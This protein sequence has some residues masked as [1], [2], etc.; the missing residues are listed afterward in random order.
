MTAVAQQA[1]TS[2]AVAEPREIEAPSP[3]RSMAMTDP[4]LGIAASPFPQDAQDVL[5]APLRDDE[6]SV[7]PD[8][9]ILYMSGEAV[10]QRLQKAFGIGGWAIKP[11]STIVDKDAVDLKG[12][13][14]PKVFYT[15]QLWIL[16]RFA[17]EATGDGNWI[18]SNPK[19]D[20]GT[21][22]EGAK[23]NCISRCCKDL[24]MWSELRDKAF[25]K[26][27]QDKNVINTAA[28]GWVKRPRQPVRPAPNVPAPRVG[29]PGAMPKNEEHHDKGKELR[30]QY[31]AT[32]GGPVPPP[33]PEDNVKVTKAAKASTV[34]DLKR[35]LDKMLPKPQLQIVVEGGIQVDNEETGERTIEEART[36][37]QNAIIHAL[38]GEL[39]LS[40]K[41]YRH[42]LNKHYHVDTS[43]VLTKAQASDLID[44]LQ[45]TKRNAEMAGV[46]YPQQKGA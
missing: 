32:V 10:R 4:F 37:E 39:Q 13:S 6:I 3:T 42:A 22:L 43:A 26:A 16:G 36:L 18:T 24:G 44:R 25:T 20:Y 41:D 40:D 30:E 23:T 31:A 1:E 11:I 38:L 17:A 34:K 21:A 19:S 27:W 9:G 46:E 15:G 14:Q 12:K 7:R 33:D 35:T 28:A 2:L 45:K 29:G 5:G 8:D